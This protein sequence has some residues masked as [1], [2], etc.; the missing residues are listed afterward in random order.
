MKFD[1]N[2]ARALIKLFDDFPLEYFLRSISIDRSEWERLIP[3]SIEQYSTE[4][5][6]WHLYILSQSNLIVPQIGLE[7]IRGLANNVARDNQESVYEI[8][9]N[10]LPKHT[11]TKQG[12]EYIQ[13]LG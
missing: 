1:E 4:T 5:V 7:E 9:K 6:L 2:I 13:E 11:L 12:G 3:Q 10:I 8:L